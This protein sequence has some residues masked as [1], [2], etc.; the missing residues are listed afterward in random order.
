M[1][2]LSD[3]RWANQCIEGHD[4]ECAIGKFIHVGQNVGQI[5]SHKSTSIEAITDHLIDFWYAEVGFEFGK[6][7]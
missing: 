3:F 5:N 6:F 1:Q 7:M 2:S 4:N